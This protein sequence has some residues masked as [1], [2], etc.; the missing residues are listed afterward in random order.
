MAIEIRRNTQESQYELLVDGEVAGIAE[1]DA[2]GNYV[3]F[4]HTELERWMRGRG[5][6]AELVRGALDDVRGTGRMV[7]P[8]CW[9]VRQFID[10]HPE[11]SDLLT[12][13][14]V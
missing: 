8:H 3:V 11:Y 6:G 5:L 7:I 1:Y 14:A 9:Y 13:V 12:R 4:P 10:E 2:A